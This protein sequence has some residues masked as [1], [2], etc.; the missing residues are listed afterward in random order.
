MKIIAWIILTPAIMVLVF[1]ILTWVLNFH[2]PQVKDIPVTGAD[3][4]PTLQI[5]QSI[6]IMTYNV[7]YMAGKNNIFFYDLP[8]RDGPDERPSQE[9]ITQTLHRVARIIRDENPDIVLLQE[10]DNGAKRT[11][12]EN[13]LERL[14]PLLPKGYVCHA[15]TFY[16]KSK[17]IP[18]PRIMGATGM[19]L[20][21]LSK[22]K[23]SE[24]TRHQLPLVPANL[25]VQQYNFKR[26]LLETRFPVRGGDDLIAINVHL[27]PFTEGTDVALKQIMELDSLLEERSHAGFPWISGGDYNLLPPG[28][29]EFFQGDE[30]SYY[31]PRSEIQTLYQKYPAIPSLQA[32]QSD[33]AKQWYTHYPNNP[34]AKG[35]N[36]TIDYIFYSGLSLVEA[37]VRRHDTLDISDH[38]PVIAVFNLAGEKSDKAVR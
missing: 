12:Y 13:Q 38:L 17:F 21:T 11:D 30:K 19:Q 29:Y 4:A 31:R 8:E 5:G 15:S 9:E 35:P 10:M 34:S 3:N 20:V 14:L 27:E 6:K 7:Q 16:W 37:R 1:L 36:K 28:H 2:P 22:Y 18:H 26:A 25:I 24:A 23:I 33:S 32:I